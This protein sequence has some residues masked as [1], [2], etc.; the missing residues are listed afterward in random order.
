M[1]E[2]EEFGKIRK[3]AADIKRSS[4]KANASMTSYVKALNDA[5][6][7]NRQMKDEQRKLNKLIKLRNKMISDGISLDDTELKKLE[8]K[9]K[10]HKE[11]IDLYDEAIE[12]LK[13]SIKLHKALGNQVKKLV[14]KG[15]KRVVKEVRDLPRYFT[16]QDKA[17]KQATLS[18]GLMGDQS[19]AMFM[20]INK[21]S[22]GTTKMGV[23]MTALSKLQQSYSE[24]V[25]KTIV[26]STKGLTAMAELQKGAF[27]GDENITAEY[28]A[29][30]ENFGIAVTDARDTMEEGVQLAQTMG[31]NASKFSQ[32]MV[33]NLKLA[34]GYN[35]KGGTK[36]LKKM[37]ALA[38]KFKLSMES[39]AGV[40]DKLITPEGAVEMAASLQVLGGAWGKLA[41]PF[42]LMYQARHDM[43]GLQE[44]IIKATAGTAQ[45]NKETQEFDISGMEM[46]RLR[47]V[48]EKLG[49]DY[50]ELAESAKSFAKDSKVK[51]MI[52]ARLTPE[53]KEF[54]GSNGMFN[55]ASGKWEMEIVDKDGKYATK[56]IKDINQTMM[57]AT[58]ADKKSL[59][60]RA[61][62]ATTFNET[63]TNFIET[64][65]TTLIP[66]LKGVNDVL[67][68]IADNFIASLTGEDGM[69]TSVAD[70]LHES[71]E[72]FGGW[73]VGL[74]GVFDTVI[75]NWEIAL[76]AVVGG[77]LLFSFLK[78]KMN[79]VALGIGFNSVART[80]G[81]GGNM[82]MQ[83]QTSSLAGRQSPFGIK[84]MD[85][86][87]YGG[88]GGM[89][90]PGMSMKGNSWGGNGMRGA[91]LGMAGMALGGGAKM[92][93]GSMDD[94]NSAGA[95]ALGVFGNAAMGAGMGAM[96]GPWGALAG[97]VLGAGYGLVDNAQRVNQAREYNSHAKGVMGDPAAQL[98]QRNAT[99][100]N[101]Y[102]MMP[103]G[104]AIIP[105][106]KDTVALID[107][108][109]AQKES[110]K[111]AKKSN[112]G[113]STTHNINLNGTLKLEGAGVTVDLVKSL[114]DDPKF[115]SWLSDYIDTA[116]KK[117]HRGVSGGKF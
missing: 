31:V 58:I 46:H 76:A 117:A 26:L 66:F 18:M 48:A 81:M 45:F 43:E 21:A 62:Q 28:A 9:I 107:G 50:K 59:A 10:F 96:F 82:S 34:Q 51:T 30:M 27:M 13:E 91:N 75:D 73:L 39:I 44:S 116:D 101:D 15:Y 11:E 52:D 93:R 98:A 74:K 17:V 47:E 90:A 100:V 99:K 20:N 56:N 105:S 84:Q 102:M 86:S 97:G 70:S 32:D 3:D 33:K 88:G 41:D 53:A 61:V 38:I 111:E 37:T 42:T 36:A 19:E 94:Q 69:L 110:K 77:G 60:E 113:G 5:A 67:K 87:K 115:K 16:E 106:R 25:G 79:G 80:G 89:K 7:L 112:N 92:W 35:F 14:D 57:D 24:K 103:N 83:G 4:E 72:A 114:A 104:D 49:M 108:E 63:L 95:Q 22:I 78:W 54:I 64:L 109:A 85:M 71:G 68:P 12:K 1:T 23:N 40:A 29:N 55:K 6:V 8:K 65:K 2:S